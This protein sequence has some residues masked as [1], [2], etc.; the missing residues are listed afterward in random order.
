MA[1]LEIAD[2]HFTYPEDT[3]QTL[4]GIRL[5]VR[6]GEFVVLCGPSGCGKTTLLRSMKSELAPVGRREGELRY[7]GKALHE[8]D[9]YFLAK[10]IGIVQQDPD[11][12]IVME[13]VIRELAFGLENIGVSTESMRRRIAE[14][15]HF[16]GMEDWLY[17]NTSELSGGQKQLVTL[18]SVLLLQP[19]VLLLDEPTAQL[20]PVAAKE[21]LQLLRRLNEEF[22]LTV[23][24]TEHRLEELLPMADRVVVMGSEGRIRYD[25]T[26]RGLAGK[27]EDGEMGEY[28]DYMP[29]LVKLA[30]SLKDKGWIP[31]DPEDACLSQATAIPLSVKEGRAWLERYPFAATADRVAGSQAKKTRVPRSLTANDSASRAMKTLLECRGV[32]FRYDKSSPFIV[33]QLD[34]SIRAGDFTAIVGGNG[35]G[36]STLLQLLSGLFRPQLGTVKFAGKHVDSVKERELRERIGYLSQNPLAYFLHDTVEEELQR[37]VHRSRHPNPSQRMQTLIERFGLEDVLAKHPHDISGGERQRAALA[38]VLLAGPEVLLLDEPTKGLDPLM[39]QTWGE[40]LQELHHEGLTIVLVTHDIEF[41]AQYA[42]CCAMLFDGAI[43]AEGP[44][45]TFFSENYFYTTTINRIVRERFPEALTYK[46][47]LDQWLVPV[48][49]S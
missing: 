11:N 41:A 12:Q 38:C 35:A 6:Q 40:L 26:P 21:F 3:E 27:L 13:Q 7:M 17:R 45:A 36:K 37:A 4:A 31:I 39:K 33:K 15:V 46:D 28:F 10:Q 30:V 2:L 8:H 43:T 49:L 25:G 20:D 47:V 5:A 42:K 34:F 29:S 22:G 24:M 23:I 18:A 14:M 48:S 1:L 44:P 9:P 16:F 32:H 19:R